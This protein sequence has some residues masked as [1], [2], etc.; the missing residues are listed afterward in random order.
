MLFEIEERP[1][2]PLFYRELYFTLAHRRPIFA[3]DMT[4]YYCPNMEEALKRAKKA[5]KRPGYWYGGI[6]LKSGK[7]GFAVYREGKVIEQYSVIRR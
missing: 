6:T 2:R 4:T 5:G 3:A 1:H 7:K